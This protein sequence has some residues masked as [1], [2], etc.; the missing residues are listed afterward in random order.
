MKLPGRTVRVEWARKDEFVSAPVG[1]AGTVGIRATLDENARPV[2]WNL[3]IWSQVHVRRPGNNDRGNFIAHDLMPGTKPEPPEL[4]DLPFHNGGGGTRNS[5]AC[6]D[7]PRQEIVHNLVDGVPVRTSSLRSL[8]AYVNILAIESFMDE[9]AEVAGEDSVDYRLSLTS[10][11]RSRAVMEHARAMASRIPEAPSG[12]GRARGFAFAR[13][14]NTAAYIAMVVE[15][16]VETEV[17]VTGV[18]AAV[19]A[20]LVV[21]PDGVRNQVEG[22]IVQSLSWTLKEQVRFEDGRIGSDS[23]DAYPILRFSEVP[24]IEIELIEN[25]DLPPLGVG[26]VSQGP[27]AAAVSNAVARA[28]GVRIRDLPLTRERIMGALLQ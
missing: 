11:P 27:T 10:D 7:L 22:G 26:E 15:V 25:Q 28:L 13:Y 2:D 14:K 19:D 5:Q 17:R 8:G 4:T 3:E 18:W 21:S 1:A 24:P 12:A 16:E 20:G 9:L 23:W 6:Y